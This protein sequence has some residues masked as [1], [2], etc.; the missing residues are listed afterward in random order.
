MLTE[1]K[2][3]KVRKQLRGGIPEGEIKSD[4]INEGYTQDEIDKIFK[5]Y[6]PD[7]RTWLLVFA[8]I[9]LVAGVYNLISSSGYLM[10]IFS[11]AM[12]VVY[13]LEVKR[14]KKIPK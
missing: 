12:F 7:M 4:L 10:L 5:A 14:I 11:G 2:I 9:F 6:R 3:K 8:I 1:E 13:S